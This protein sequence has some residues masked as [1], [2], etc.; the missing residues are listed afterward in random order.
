MFVLAGQ[1]LVE[2]NPFILV[3]DVERMHTVQ[4]RVWSVEYCP[5]PDLAP[6]LQI[7]KFAEDLALPG[8]T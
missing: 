3:W 5:W 7:N 8:V 2:L 4:F 1:T 6:P